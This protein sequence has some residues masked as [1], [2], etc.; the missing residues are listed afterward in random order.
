MTSPLIEI[1]HSGTR[2][3]Y[4]VDHGAR[5]YE[6]FDAEECSIGLFISAGS[7]TSITREIRK[8]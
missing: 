1:F 5:G 6:A 4:V 3:G 8:Q 2:I 7:A